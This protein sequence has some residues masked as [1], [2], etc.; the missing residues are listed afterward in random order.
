MELR[1]LPTGP[2]HAPSWS[3]KPPHWV[4]ERAK[5]DN[6]RQ[7]RHINTG[8]EVTS[9]ILGTA[10][11]LTPR[12]LS[13]VSLLSFQGQ[14]N[15]LHSFPWARRGC[16]LVSPPSMLSPDAGQSSKFPLVC[17]TWMHLLV[18]Q[19][20]WGCTVGGKH[21]GFPDQELVAPPGARVVFPWQDWVASCLH[22]ASW[23]DKGV[24]WYDVRS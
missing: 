22:G 17:A 11:F 15:C 21:P 1:L 13:A 4:R 20:A 7:P 5:P 12:R 18:L 19:T 8:K 9:G 16:R 24:K 6:Q 3:R 14:E 23:P 10:A 2:L